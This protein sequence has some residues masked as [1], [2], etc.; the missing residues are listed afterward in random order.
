MDVVRLLMRYMLIPCATSL[1]VVMLATNLARVPNSSRYLSCTIV[2]NSSSIFSYSVGYVPLLGWAATSHDSGLERASLRSAVAPACRASLRASDLVRMH[3]YC[4]ERQPKPVP[5]CAFASSSHPIQS[6]ALS[7]S[8][9]QRASPLDLGRFVPH[10]EF[11][12]HSSEVICELFVN[13]HHF[14]FFCVVLPVFDRKTRSHTPYR[15]ARG[16]LSIG[17]SLVDP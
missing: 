8:S 5:F 16:F 12:N 13:H 15:L 1:K 4:P 11:L 2:G 10:F 9:A 17:K 6:A 3:V 7:S 14:W